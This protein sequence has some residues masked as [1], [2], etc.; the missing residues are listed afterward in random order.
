M[1]R[2]E[3]VQILERHGINLPDAK[4]VIVGIRGYRKRTMGNPTRNDRNIYDDALIVISECGE[5]KTFN[6]NVDPSFYRKGIASL[7]PGIYEVVKWKHR[8]QYDALQIVLDKVSRDG[9]AGFD[10]G[11]HG[12]NFHYGGEG[13]TWSEGCQT[14]PKSVY[15]IFLRLV[16][17]LMK[18]HKLSKVKYLLIE[19]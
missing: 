12:I 13:S 1:S 5:Y 10:S 11:R 8:G 14:L 9:Q 4:V 19:N 6:A 2:A 7:L 16:Y 18:K 3:T 17:A 15:W